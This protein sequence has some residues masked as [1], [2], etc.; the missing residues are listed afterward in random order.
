[1]ILSREARIRLTCPQVPGAL[2]S[3]PAPGHSKA[4]RLMGLLIPSDVGEI[5]HQTREMPGI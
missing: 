5:L 4:E 1:M 2:G 3:A